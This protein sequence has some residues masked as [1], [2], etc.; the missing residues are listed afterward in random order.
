MALPPVDRIRNHQQPRHAGSGVAL[1]RDVPLQHLSDG[2]E[3]DR[4][5]QP[6]YLDRHAQAHRRAEAAARGRRRAGRRWSRTRRTRQRRGGRRSSGRRRHGSRGGGGGGRRARRR[7]RPSFT[8]P[9]CTIPSCAIRAATFFPPIRP[10]SPPPPNSSTHCSRTASRSAGHRGISRS[11]GKSYP[12][13]SYVVKTAQAFRPAR[14]GHVRAAGPPQRFRLSRRPSQSALRHHRL[15][16]GHADGREVR[17]HPATASTVRSP[18]STACCP[19][20]PAAV[21]GA[22]Q[23]GRLSDQ[24]ST[25]TI[26]SS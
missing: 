24:P 19:P 13:G 17:P 18:R 3:L 8:T 11:N 15:D 14:D 5:G 26:P 4:E 21:T 2:H 9:F 7:F 10:I 6:G 25:S 20:P 1:S 12:S 23:P 22:G 16:A